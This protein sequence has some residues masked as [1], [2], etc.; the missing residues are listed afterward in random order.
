MTPPLR[1]WSASP[2]RAFVQVCSDAAVLVWCWVWIRLGNV[3]HDAIVSVGEV[4]YTLEGGASGIKDGL[5]GAAGQAGRIP[6]VGDTFGQPFT[7]AGGAAGTIA[8]AG[9]DLGDRVTGLALPLALVV[10]LAPILS[11]VLLWG[12]ARYR[13]ARRAGE[14]AQLAL[15]PGGERLL[16]LRALATRPVHRIVAVS[17]DA[18]DAWRR[19]DHVVVARLAALEM[20]RCGVRPPPP[21]TAVAGP[22]S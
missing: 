21:R 16:A 13:F 4:G 18:V 8:G 14:T 12:P 17:P 2:G 19:D 1:P 22:G 7:A 3:V 20:S 5:D 11:V 9:R 6:V 10:A 15:T